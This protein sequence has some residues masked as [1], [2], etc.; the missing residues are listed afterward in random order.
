VLFRG[1]NINPVMFR[2]LR[3]TADQGG[4]PIQIKG[5]NRGTSN[6]ANVLQLIRGGVATA[7]LGIPLRYMHSPVE[8]ISLED[9][10]SASELIARFI[11]SVEAGD[12][13]TPR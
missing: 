13:F 8:L 6:D 7:C 3:E 11:L 5:A 1:P 10:E 12:D 4:I 2:R 9:L